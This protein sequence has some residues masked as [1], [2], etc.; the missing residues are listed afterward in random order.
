M[1]G[2]EYYII[3]VAL[4]TTIILALGGLVGSFLPRFVTPVKNMVYKTALIFVI[5]IPLLVVIIPSWSIGNYDAFSNVWETVISPVYLLNDSEDA[6]SREGVL[7]G[8]IIWAA[9][10]WFIGFIVVLSRIGQGIYRCRNIVNKST[11]AADSNLDKLIIRLRNRLNINK[12]PKVVYSEEKI[13]PFVTGIF[14]PVVVLPRSMGNSPAH[15][16]EMV[17]IHELAHIKRNDVVWNYI[18]SLAAALHWYNPL[19]WLIRRKTTVESDKVCDSYVLESGIGAVDYAEQ[20]IHFARNVKNIRPV[21]PIEVRLARKKQ[22]E[23]RIMSILKDRNRL[24]PLGRKGIFTAAVFGIV[25][26]IILSGMQL[27]AAEP[28]AKSEKSKELPS[29]N[30]DK[31]PAIDEFVPVDVM[32]EMIKMVEPEFPV[33]SIKDE[34][35]GIVWIKALVDKEGKVRD[36][37]VLKSSGVKAMEDAALESAKK[38]EFKPAMQDGKPVATWV[39]YSVTFDLKDKPEKKNSKTKKE[40]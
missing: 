19:V 7:S 18:G 26:M 14:S 30:G 21:F 27:G 17:L 37:R 31:L 39:A 23:V 28:Q 1:S 5:L 6:L 35:E 16:I 40:K 33:K 4:K 2:T 8:W 13:G 12:V 38:C 20:L 32:P 36:A 29:V 9:A 22:L 10:I 15:E 3:E 11:A 24:M 25:I 34:V